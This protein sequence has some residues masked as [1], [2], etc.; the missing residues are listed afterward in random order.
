MVT[1]FTRQIGGVIGQM[2]AAEI[3][4]SGPDNRIRMGY[5]SFGKKPVDHLFIQKVE[6]KGC[7]EVVDS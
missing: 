5:E 2:L 1:K 3:L 4:K 6:R 7:K